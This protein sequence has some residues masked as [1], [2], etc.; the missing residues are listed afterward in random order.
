MPFIDTKIE[1]NLK[2]LDK[3]LNI[4][5]EKAN[6]YKIDVIK[7][8]EN[9]D[10]IDFESFFSESW[11]DKLKSWFV[12]PKS[13]ADMDFEF[14]KEFNSEESKFI[15]A[16]WYLH[17]QGLV[18]FEPFPVNTV[19]LTFA[20]IIKISNGGFYKEYKRQKRRDSFQNYFWLVAIMTFIAGWILKPLIELLIK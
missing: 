12:K 18:F 5:L 2:Y 17:S 15:N 13:L 20:G 3:I 19:L 14:P 7:L 9:I 4:S 8:A 6:N 1:D 11:A 16:L 10:P